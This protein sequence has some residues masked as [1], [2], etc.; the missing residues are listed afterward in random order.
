M[1]SEDPK[2][3]D[4]PQ[5][6][7]TKEKEASSG[8]LLNPM[9][10]DRAAEEKFKEKYGFKKAPPGIAQRKISATGG[11][12]YFDSGDYNKSVT[13]QDRQA[14]A[15]LPH[16]RNPNLAQM[17]AKAVVHRTQPS[18]LAAGTAKSPLTN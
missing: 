9:K 3:E 1:S 8:N 6:E 16:M 5:E 7:Q 14:I 10:T 13:R 17:R 15:H 11:K 2:Q 12:Q 4:A 18:K